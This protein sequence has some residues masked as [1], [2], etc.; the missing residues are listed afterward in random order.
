MPKREERKKGRKERKEKKQ[1]KRCVGRKE[2]KEAKKPGTMLRSHLM[3]AIIYLMHPTICLTISLIFMKA[4][5]QTDYGQ[6]GRQVG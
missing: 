2:R 5:G 3:D 1:V 4:D 6:T